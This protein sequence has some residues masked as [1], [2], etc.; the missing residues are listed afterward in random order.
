MSWTNVK[1]IY[2]REI[3]DQ[4]RDRRTLFTIAVLPVLLYPLL[5]TTFL[6]ISQF[7]QE[8]PTKVWMV[9]EDQV[10][11]STGSGDA[12]QLISD[13]RFVP[14]FCPDAEADLID[15]ELSNEPTAEVLAAIES[16]ISP[17]GDQAPDEA[18]LQQSRSLVQQTL[19]A[20][21]YDVLVYFP[22]DFIEQVIDPRNV[23]LNLDSTHDQTGPELLVLVNSASDKS[24]I[25]GGRIDAV[26]SRWRKAIVRHNLEEKSVSIAATEPFHLVNTDIAAEQSRRA[27]IWSKIL[28]FVVLIWA[29]TGAFYPAID[30]C[31]GEKERGTLETLLSSPAGR[32]EIVWGKLLTIMTF[33]ASTAMLN[34]VSMGFTGMFVINQFQKV[35]LES[36]QFDF[37]PPPI[38]AMGWLVVLMLPMSALFSALSLA[39]A[40]FARSSKEG[41]YYLMPL[42]VIMLPLMMLTMLP[43]AEL[44]LGT[45]LI[46]VAGMLLLLRKLIEGQYVEAIR[47]AI[48]VLG[49]TMVCCLLAIKWAVNQFNNESVLFRE[50][51]RTGLGVW[52]RHLVRDRGLTPTF[53]EAILCGT[54][55]LVIRF[56][57]NFMA[58]M[59]ADWW[60]FARIQVVQLIAFVAAPALLMT[61]MLT[62]SPART[63]S[64]GLPFPLAIPAAFILAVLINPAVIWFGKLVIHVY[65]QSSDFEKLNE[66]LTSIFNQAPNIWAIIAVIALAPAILEELAFRGFILSGLQKSSRKTTA[67]VISSLF[68]GLAH[69]VLQQSIVAFGTG[70]LLGYIAVQARSIWPCIVFHF[71]NNSLA[72]LISTITPEVLESVPLLGLIFEHQTVGTIQVATYQVIPSVLSIT[73]AMG[74]I[75]WFAKLAR[76]DSPSKHSTEPIEDNAAKAAV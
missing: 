54:L 2:Q 22:T 4:L 39:V 42:L 37:G 73:L 35:G 40:A 55:I 26:L 27:A 9:G 52:L 36:S 66:L 65:P 17:Q 47:F 10:A 48:P 8:H 1:L 18:K 13:G 23:E 28:P 74:L 31:A 50:G 30:L 61:V 33:S 58:A 43:G 59:P 53:G 45:A 67:I 3:R 16:L 60:D 71:V 34:L 62:R 19:Q 21:D 5:G 29:L 72:V 49:V 56:F 24:R 12:I 69:S 41:Q 70:L 32:S 44:D 76:G 11:L 25:A 14:E 6:Q 68:F 63:L 75:Y 15:L 7:L 57:V 51:E 64:L 38:Y 46:P 20:N